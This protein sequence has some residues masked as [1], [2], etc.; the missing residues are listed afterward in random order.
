MVFLWLKVVLELIGGRF[1]GFLIHVIHGNMLAIM[2]NIAVTK[3]S[4]TSH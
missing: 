1:Y 4:Y 2:L 3:H